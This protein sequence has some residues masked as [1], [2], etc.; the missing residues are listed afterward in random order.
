MYSVRERLPSRRTTVHYD[1]DLSTSGGRLKLHLSCSV[2][3]DGRL[4]EIA[5]AHG[6]AGA[7]I[8]TMLTMWAITASIALQNGAPVSNIVKALR[9]VQDATGGRIRL[10]EVPSVDGVLCTSL[11]DAISKILDAEFA[12]KTLT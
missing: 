2:Y 11:W 7:V 9:N 8:R 10:P 3:E 1:V 6:K 12:S 4:G 5:I